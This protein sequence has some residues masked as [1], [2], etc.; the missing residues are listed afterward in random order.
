MLPLAAKESSMVGQVSKG[1]APGS[2]S[3][4]VT[5]QVD[6]ES[7]RFLKADKEA[8]RVAHLQGLR[9]YFRQQELCS[10]HLATEERCPNAP[11]KR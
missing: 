2:R 5:R 3:G 10:G 6:I 8:R 11:E 1:K 9:Q 4:G 7:Y